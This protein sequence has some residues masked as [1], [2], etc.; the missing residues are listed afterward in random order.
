MCMRLIPPW[1]ITA[2]P[3]SQAACVCADY[4]I[5]QAFRMQLEVKVL[6]LL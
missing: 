1:L 5:W 2:Q 3:M 6:G 4:I